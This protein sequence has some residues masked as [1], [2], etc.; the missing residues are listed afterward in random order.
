MTF[1]CLL[2]SS[3]TSAFPPG[4][5]HFDRSVSP[6]FG[7]MRNLL[8]MSVANKSDAWVSLIAGWRWLS[9]PCC[10]DSGNVWGGCRQLWSVLWDPSDSMSTHRSWSVLYCFQHAFFFHMLRWYHC[11]CCIMCIGASVI[12]FIIPPGHG[13]DFRNGTILRLLWILLR[14]PWWGSFALHIR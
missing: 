7:V 3:S 8:F 5:W 12:C 6:T 14:F 10:V 11:A 9:W 1:H 13:H 4:S 2:K